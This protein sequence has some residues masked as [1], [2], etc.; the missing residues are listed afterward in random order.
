MRTFIV[1][2]S[3][4]DTMAVGAESFDIPHCGA[5]VLYRRDAHGKLVLFRSFAP[6]VWAE[7]YEGE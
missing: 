7:I 4:G 1:T 6:G 2:S 3:E 5:L